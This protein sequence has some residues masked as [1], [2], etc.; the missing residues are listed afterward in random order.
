MANVTLTNLIIDGTGVSDVTTPLTQLLNGTEVN[1]VTLN[2][3]D[4]LNLK[5]NATYKIT[6]NV[7]VSD[8]YGIN[9]KWNG[10]T[11]TAATQSANEAHLTFRRCRGWTFTGPGT[12]VGA[13]PTAGTYTAGTSGQHGVQFQGSVWMFLKEMTITSVA[14][15][16][17]AAQDQD[18]SGTHRPCR[19]IELFKP[20]LSG[21]GFHAFYLTNCEGFR[22]SGGTVG[23]IGKS[24]LDLE[25]ASGM[26]I[27]SVGIG[28]V[29]L[30]TFTDYLVNGAGAGTLRG[31]DVS[32]NTFT[33]G[34]QL[35]ALIV[36][37]AGRWSAITF[38]GNHATVQSPSTVT[39]A[40]ALTNVDA[41]KLRNNLSRWAAVDNTNVV[42]Y[43]TCTKAEISH[44]RFLNA[45]TVSSGE[46]G[47]STAFDNQIT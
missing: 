28:D 17:I 13:D 45:A 19:T 46:D 35:R 9:F 36:A 31:V 47:T 3:F 26:G 7:L 11:I 30:G 32:H 6:S 25:P 10:A 5:P 18:D 1:G 2:D 24:V 39:N 34:K 20:T 29:S 21:A 23:T 44:N 37:P 40:I 4:T 16:F 27:T 43:T 15:S 33:Q 41:F 14:G 22:V 42:A 12:I 38:E 8:R